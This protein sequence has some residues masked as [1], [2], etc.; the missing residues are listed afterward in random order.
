MSVSADRY[1]N[2]KDKLLL[3]VGS[4]FGQLSFTMQKQGK[5]NAFPYRLIFKII[6]RL[7]PLLLLPQRE[8]QPLSLKGLRASCQSRCL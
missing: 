1:T 5:A 7:L 8:P 3:Y 6:Q 2:S 4:Q